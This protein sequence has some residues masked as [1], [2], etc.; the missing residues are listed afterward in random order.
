MLS[1][2]T[3]FTSGS[4]LAATIPGKSRR[5]QT[6]RAG[7]KSRIRPLE[8]RDGNAMLI[9]FDNDWKDNQPPGY[10]PILRLSEQLL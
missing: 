4:R 6:E 1:L 5:D 2:R 9:A 7:R 8:L 3:L 10:E